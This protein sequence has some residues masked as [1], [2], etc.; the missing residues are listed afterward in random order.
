MDSYDEVPYHSAPFAETHPVNLAVLG[1]LF[2]LETPD[3]DRCR[4]LELGCASGGNLIPMAVHLPGGWFEGIELSAAQAAEG[5]SL[6]A[7]LGL[8]NARIRQGRRG[9][10]GSAPS[11]SRR[12][13]WPT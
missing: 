13:A 2:G 4:Y 6:V 5:A 12:V 3:P 8:R 9:S 11:T 1:R 10:S 7:E